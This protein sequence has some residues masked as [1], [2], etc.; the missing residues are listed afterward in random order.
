MCWLNLTFHRLRLS[1]YLYATLKIHTHSS[2]SLTLH[3]PPVSHLLSPP[4]SPLLSLNGSLSQS[5][6]LFLSLSL[7]LSPTHSLN[8]SR[9]RPPPHC[10]SLFPFNFFN[11]ERLYQEITNRRRDSRRKDQQRQR[12]SNPSSN[13]NSSSNLNSSSNVSS[14]VA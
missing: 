5:H 13:M 11:R 7:S 3:F 4:L 14:S 6:I 8:H 10:L 1:H 9:P 12:R 2:T